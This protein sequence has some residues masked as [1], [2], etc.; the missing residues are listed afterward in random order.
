MSDLIYDLS[1]KI[2]QFG[3]SNVQEL[4]GW[5]NNENIPVIN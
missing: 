1:F 4:V 2:N 3:Q 5:I